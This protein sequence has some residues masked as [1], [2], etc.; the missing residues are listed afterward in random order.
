MAQEGREIGEGRGERGRE[1]KWGD[2]GYRVN[3]IS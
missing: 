2:V 1:G 3:S